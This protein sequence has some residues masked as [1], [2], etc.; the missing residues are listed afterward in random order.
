MKYAAYIL[1]S[2][3]VAITIIIQPWLLGDIVAFLFLGVIPGTDLVLPY[4][5]MILIAAITGAALIGW[6]S[7][8]QLYIGDVAHQDQTA[9][10]VARKKVMKL[11]A[12][13][14]SKSRTGGT[15]ISKRRATMSLR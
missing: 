6:L 3:I 8:Q 9:R 4:W 7:R 1:L 10:R 13:P 14:T 2:V 15:R 11:A 5:A 12:Q